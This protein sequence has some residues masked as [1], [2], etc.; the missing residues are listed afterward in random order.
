MTIII[1][2]M[3]QTQEK[4][5]NG[6]LIGLP[7]PDSLAPPSLTHCAT[8]QR[9]GVKSCNKE[10]TLKRQQFTLLLLSP[11]ASQQHDYMTAHGN[12]A[13]GQPTALTILYTYCTGGTEWFSCKPCCLVDVAVVRALTVQATYPE[14]DP[15]QLPTLH[16]SL[17]CCL[18]SISYYLTTDHTHS[19]AQ[20]HW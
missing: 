20:L 17:Y 18:I 16:F 2:S 19:D 3:Q 1:R 11:R 9:L 13:T 6:S 5:H 14:F 10:S 15:Q 12:R 7:L 4:S 8:G